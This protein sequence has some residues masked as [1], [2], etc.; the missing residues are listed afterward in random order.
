MIA[1][2]SGASELISAANLLA[3]FVA[4]VNSYFDQI[5]PRPAF[6]IKVKGQALIGEVA[7]PWEAHPGFAFTIRELSCAEA[8]ALGS[9]L[10]RSLEASI[11]RLG[12]SQPLAPN[13]VPIE[14]AR[15]AEAEQKP[16]PTSSNDDR[17]GFFGTRSVWG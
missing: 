17:E 13:V 11:D 16:A 4:K 14:A 12:A 6:A 5:K 10:R 9:R 3:D 7:I 2:L 8:D 15:K 1:N